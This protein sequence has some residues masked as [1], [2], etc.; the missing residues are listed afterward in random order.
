MYRHYAI[1]VALSLCMAGCLPPS[2]TDVKPDVKPDTASQLSKA[3]TDSARGYAAALGSACREQSDKAG[4]FK[5]WD[6]LWKSFHASTEKAR[7]ESFAGFEDSLSVSFKSG[8]VI[9]YDADT[10]RQVFAEAADG[11]DRAGVAKAEKE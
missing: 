9:P 11:F 1:I 6:E 3:A 10:V 4:Q 5:T 2:H 7:H 8:E